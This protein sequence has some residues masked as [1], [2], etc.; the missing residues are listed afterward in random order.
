M[1]FSNFLYNNIIFG[2]LGHN[3]IFGSDRLDYILGLAGDDTLNGK[4]NHDILLGGN[5]DDSF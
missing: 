2:T 4:E 5:G 3:S 1:T